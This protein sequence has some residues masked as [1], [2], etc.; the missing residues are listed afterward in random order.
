MH[1]S[2]IS[3]LPPAETIR[4]RAEEIVARPDYQIEPAESHPLSDLWWDL[5][6]WAVTPLRWLFEALEGLPNAMRWIIVILLT[7]ILVLLI[8]HIVWTF[9]VAIRGPTVGRKVRRGNRETPIDPR[10]LEREAETLGSHGDYVAAV[11]LLFH[12]S[13]LRLQKFEKKPFRPGCTNRELLRRYRTSKL[14]EPLQ[15][16]VE[17]IDTTWYGGRPCREEDYR[18][19]REGHGEIRQLIGKLSHAVGA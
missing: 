2:L 12:A 1:A 10:D 9:V 11:R 13:L 3:S 17:T 5:L 16:F 19:C 7:T 14:H 18:A 15:R 6:E 8:A 4:R